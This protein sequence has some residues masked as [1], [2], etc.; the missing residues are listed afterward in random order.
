VTDASELTPDW[1]DE[2][3]EFLMSDHAP[4]DC[5]QISDLDGFL[6]GVAIGPEL[7]MPSEWMP[8]FWQGEPNFETTEHAESIIGAIMARYNEIIHQLDDEPGA[9]EP[10]FFETPDGSVLAADWAEG[11][12]EAVR[13]RADMWDPLFED[14][15]ARLLFAPIMAHLHDKEG[16][17]HIDGSPEEML[18]IRDENAQILP[19]AIK[20]IHDFWKARRQPANPA[21][22]P[23]GKKVGRNE[24]C[25]CGSGRKYKRCCGAN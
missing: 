6:T 16:K 9:F 8:V 3:D 24:P 14:E 15:D 2:L 1:I 7:I 13:L 11:F 21:R 4:D 18:K 25:P 20:G 10:I 23:A 17:P 5:L 19:F 22:E 12:M